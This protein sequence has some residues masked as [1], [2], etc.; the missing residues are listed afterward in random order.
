MRGI[1]V[2]LERPNIMRLTEKNKKN[3]IEN[4]HEHYWAK[5]NH[6]GDCSF[7][8][9]YSFYNKSLKQTLFIVFEK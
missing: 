4:E 5:M 1:L 6:N 9:R 2:I 3:N 7:K 8:I